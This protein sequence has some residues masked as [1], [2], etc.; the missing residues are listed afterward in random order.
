MAGR[1][2]VMEVYLSGPVVG[3]PVIRAGV[4]GVVAPTG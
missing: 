2:A 4:S 1:L 3:N